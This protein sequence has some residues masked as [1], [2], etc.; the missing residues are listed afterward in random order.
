[1]KFFDECTNE[2]AKP[3]LIKG[4]LALD[5][6]SSWYGPAGG[7]KSSLLTDIAVHGAAGRDWRGFKTKQKFGTV[8][9]ALERAGLQR[10]RLAAYAKRDGHAG[11]PIAVVDQIVDLTDEASVRIVIATITT[12][13]ERFGVP[14]GLAIF[15]TYAKAVAAG[16]GDEDKAQHV[17]L[18]AANLKRI[19]DQLGQPIHLATIGHTGKDETKGE[20]GS[21]AK[22][23]HIDLGVQISGDKVKTATITKANDQPEGVLTSFVGQ[24]VTV[25]TDADGDDLTAFIVSPMAVQ[26]APEQASRLS[27]NQVNALDTLKTTIKDHGQKGAVAVHAWKE[28][29]FRRGVLDRDAPN[30][31]EPF[32]RLK[33]SLIKTQRIEEDNGMVRFTSTNAI[34]MTTRA[35]AGIISP[36]P[37]PP[38][39][40]I[41]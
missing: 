31:R 15:D 13:Q 27:D 7:L 5:E 10:R 17:N 25:G 4:V 12:A 8:Y 28:E 2:P 38:P 34:P 16:G 39:I 37:V 26:A 3:W 18:V 1:M 41:R 35:A 33:A 11:L 24:E 40:P 19:H 6:D 22:T 21:S 32:R 36:C 14:V 30:P 9:F 23:G 29:L 20:R